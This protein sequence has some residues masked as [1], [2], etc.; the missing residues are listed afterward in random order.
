MAG[1]A[2]LGDS[3]TLSGT[4]NGTGSITFT[5]T[6]PDNT[7]ITVG[8]V[9]VSGNGT[10]TAPTVAANQVGTYTWHATYSGDG[11]NNGAVDNGSTD[12]GSG[13]TLS[14]GAAS[15]TLTTS[16]TETAGGLVGSSVLGDSAAL[17]GSYNG[18]GSITFTLTAPN[19]STTTVGSVPVSGDGTYT[20][21]SVTATQ[22]GTYTWHASYSG[23][24]LNNGAVDNGVNES[25]TTVKASPAV[26]T[27][28]SETAGGLVGSSVLG[29]SATL[30]GS[31]NGTGSITFTLTAPNGNTTTVG[32]R[33]GLGQ[34]H[35]QRADGR[36]H[37]SRHLHL[38]RQLQRR[39]LEQRRLDNGVN[40]SLTTVKASP[41][42][43]TSASETAGGLVGSSVLGDSA[44]LSGAYNGTGS[45]TFT[46]TAPNGN[47]TTVG[48]RAGLGQRHVQ[49]PT[50]AATQV[51][52]YT[53]HASYSG[54]GLNNGALDN[55]VNESLTTVKASPAVTTSASETAGGLVGSS[56]LSDSATLSG[57]YNGT[58]SITFTLTGPNGST[59]TVG[60]RAGLGQRH[61]QLAHRHRHASRHLHLARQ[62]QWRL[63]NNGAVDNGV[64]RIADHRQGQPDDQHPG[65]RNQQRHVWLGPVDRHGHARGRLQPD[66]HHHLHRHRAEQHHR[67]GGHG[68]GQ[69][70]RHLH[71]AGDHRHA[72]SAPTRSTPLTAATR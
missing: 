9:P 71:L 50:V 2:M 39:W 46:L 54:D 65:Q 72:R 13:E 19:G 68:H 28:A 30:T 44:T 67:H 20:A 22:V 42:V 14:T 8:T 21:P 57:S 69:R 62:L 64:E 58:G 3:A 45:I 55:G 31:Y 37:A 15:P 7:T 34:R 1:T 18:T 40:E 11:L 6:Q 63:L 5:L 32:T 35:L 66:R 27:S 10:Y 49:R 4:Y 29:D 23:D 38:A 48:Q 43:T 51:G 53:W 17:A 47:T 26:T 70:Q 56:V 24:S 25:L 36:R 61:L 52:T 60:H 12:N 59:T 33:A 16:A 41:A